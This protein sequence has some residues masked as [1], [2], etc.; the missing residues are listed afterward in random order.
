[1]KKKQIEE[2]FAQFENTC[3][4][5]NGIECWSARE[6]QNI[7]GYSKWDNFKNTLEKAKNRVKMQA[8]LLQTILPISGKWLILA[9]DL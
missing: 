4:I 3:Y 7:F 5:F 2:L 1:M 6:L 8:N 9:A